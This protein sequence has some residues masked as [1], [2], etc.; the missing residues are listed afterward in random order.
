MR[1]ILYLTVE[2]LN[3]LSINELGI[4]L[5][6]I[7]LPEDMEAIDYYEKNYNFRYVAGCYASYW[8]SKRVDLRHYVTSG[9]VADITDYINDKTPYIYTTF[10]DTEY[11]IKIITWKMIKCVCIA[12]IKV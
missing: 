6:V 4:F 9:Y 10:L 7:Y 2:E 8:T 5:D 12:Q 3:V 11:E 1:R